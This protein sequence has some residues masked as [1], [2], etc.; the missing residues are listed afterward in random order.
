MCNETKIVKVSELYVNQPVILE[1]RI[2]YALQDLP[3]QQSV[4][5]QR[6]DGE[7]FISLFYDDE[8]EVIVMDKFRGFEYVSNRKNNIEVDLPLRATKTSAGYDFYAPYDIEIKPQEK[9]FFWTDIKSYMKPDEVL[10]LD[11]RSSIG[12]KHDLMLANTI[13]VID[14]DY[15]NNQD[16]EGNIGICL[17]NL[18]PSIKLDGYE[19]I[20]VD[21]KII[22]IPKVID[23]TEQNTVKI[24]AGDRVA[25]GIFVKYL[26]SDNC[27]S[28]KDRKSGFGSSNLNKEM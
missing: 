6:S 10:L 1:G 12:V 13:G 18:K 14:S 11:V 8:V 4:L 9:V 19:T 27:N 2:F 28:N 17:R 25:Q 3:E 16:N 24:K 21:S 5:L 7:V 15:Y 22:N 26:E 20:T 23:L